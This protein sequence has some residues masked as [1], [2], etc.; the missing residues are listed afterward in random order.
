MSYKNIVTQTL[1]KNR[2]AVTLWT[3]DGVE[4]YEFQN[5]AYEKCY[6]KNIGSGKGAPYGV[7]GITGKPS[8]LANG[9]KFI[10]AGACSSPP[11]TA[12]GTIGVLVSSA[13]RMKPRPNSCN[14]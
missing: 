9:F 10:T 11:I 6:E 14:W 12:M 7:M 3:D 8:S 4:Q 5:Y 1:G 13:R 2:H